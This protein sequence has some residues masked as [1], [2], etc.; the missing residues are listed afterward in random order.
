VKFCGICEEE[1]GLA[2]PADLVIPGLQ[3]EP[4]CLCEDCAK[5]LFQEVMNEEFNTPIAEQTVQ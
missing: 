5:S 3:G 4:I 1:K 2:I